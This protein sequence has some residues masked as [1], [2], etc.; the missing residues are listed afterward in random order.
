VKQQNMVKKPD[1]GCRSRG[2]NPGSVDR[3]FQARPPSRFAGRC[4]A[5]EAAHCPPL[6]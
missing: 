2:H 6:A 3:S 4:E 5:S 1:R